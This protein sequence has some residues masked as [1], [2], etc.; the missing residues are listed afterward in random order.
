MLLTDTTQWVDVVV[1]D[2][3]GNPVSRANLEA[4]VYKLDWRNWWESMD[5]E[6]ANYIGNTY[7]SPL[8]TKAFSVVNG[9]GRFSFRV[10]H[11]EWGRFYIR[12][13]DPVS[14]H[15]AGRIVYLDWPGWAGRPL[16][17]NPE[18]ASMLTFNSDKQKYKVG[19]TA[20]VI[21]P[22]SGNGNALISIESGS[23]ILIHEWLPV[24]AKEIRHKF[25]ITPEMTPNVYVHVTLIQPHANSENDMPMR[26]YGVIPIFVEDPE[27]NLSPV[28][29]MPA[30][31]EPLSKYSIQ[32]SESNKRDMT[33][34]LAIVEDGLLDLTRFKTPDPW[35][36]FYAREA[37]GVRT[38]DLYDLVIGAF[39]GKLES[40]LGIGGDEN[41]VNPGSSEKANRFKPVVK[42]LGP[43]SLK[44]GKTNSHQVSLPN[45]IGSVRVMVVA[46]QAGAYGFTEKT[47]PVK[48]P[49]MVLA[50]LP[51]V[52][53][54]AESVKLPVTVFAMDNQVK[55]VSVTIK[56]NDLLMIDGPSSK[57]VTFDKTGDKIV[58]FDLKVA[59]RIGIGKVQVTATSGK[60][61][62]S[63]D[64][65]LDVRNANP[66][67]T[68]FTGNTIDAG[69]TSEISYSLP[70]M[71]GSNTAVLEVSSIPPIDIDRRLKYLIMYPHGCVEQITSSVFPQLFLGDIMDLDDKTKARTDENIKAGIRKLMTFQQSGGGFAYW[72]GQGYFSAWASSYAGNFL[73]E[74]EKKGYAL[75]GGLKSSW[76][77]SQRQMA[78]QWTGVKYNDVYI[79]DDLEQAYRLY[80]LALAGEPE[81]SAMNR[82][83]E[84]KS[85]SLMAKYRLAAAYALSGQPNIAKELMNKD[86]PDIQSYKGFYSSYGSRERDWAML[87]ET[88]LLIDD[89]MKAAVLMKKVSEALSSQMWMSTQTTAYCLMAASKF[90]KTGNTSA[91]LNFDYKSGNTKDL[92]VVSRKPV[93]NI[94][95]RLGQN[96]TTGSVTITNKNKGILFVRII[97]EGIPE[98]GNETEFS[99][100]LKIDVNYYTREGKELDV[101]RLT[102]GTDFFAKVTVTNPGILFYRDLALTQIFPPGWEINNNRMWDNELAVN[103]DNPT[104]QDI[105]DDR[106]YT[107]F[108]IARGY[109]K[110]FVVQLNASYLGRYY[111]TGTYCEAMYDNSISAMKK[112]RWIEIVPAG[113]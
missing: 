78:R 90:A 96:A 99:N 4:Y 86:V 85:L 54:P 41:A 2:D 40:I 7:N 107:Y 26:L 72:P 34:T 22:A 55:D 3:K 38:W 5:D 64:L 23:R 15:S 95:L 80:T 63:Y 30:S 51:R 48:K 9:K 19:E 29:K 93:T 106:I 13:S 74:A 109:S 1:V 105:R 37:L 87:L 53:G 17:D 76:I 70:G 25:Q 89:K 14:N 71:A 104:Y 61:T 6:L 113:E 45:Y 16:R 81:M 82:L 108:D 35:N 83:R 68:T 92:T 98:A 11:P 43:F 66:P 46:G 44:G 10:D 20:E 36:D 33:Y 52:L 112:G 8:M 79:Q 110:S 65:E 58:G 32:V 69:K 73:L 47:V 111:L 67:V 42:F 75:P 84:Y 39:G 94:P 49:L 59:S 18:A 101:S 56:T 102:Q 21:I 60:I 57:T 24:T 77:K 100:E 12:V 27:T 62:S 91:G 88:Y 31:L 28:I 97:M 50:T 103:K